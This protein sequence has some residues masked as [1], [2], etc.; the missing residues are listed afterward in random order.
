M[1]GSDSNGNPANYVETEQILEYQGTRCSLV[2]IRGSI[3]L[4]WS[5]FPNL[6]YKPPPV[7]T[8][9]GQ[10]QVAVLKVHLEHVIQT[11]GSVVLVNLINH[12]GPEQKMEKAFSNA[13]RTLNNQMVKFE[14]FDFHHECRKMRWDRLSIL[15]DRIQRDMED[16]GYFHISSDGNILR[17]QEGVFRTNCIDSLDRTNVVQG[18]IAKYL[19]EAQ[20]KILGLLPPGERIED[21]QHFQSV[22]RNG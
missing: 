11:Y 14:S 5:Q 10:E 15:M 21:Y 7:P 2:Q 16:F 12:T 4:F 13:V 3:P 22:Y 17:L 18:L 8:S 9:T 20:L 6:K 19:L 1:R